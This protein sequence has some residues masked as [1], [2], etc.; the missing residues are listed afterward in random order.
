[1]STVAVK[2]K[3]TQN[4]SIHLLSL[5]K[6]CRFFTVEEAKAELKDLICKV[7]DLYNRTLLVKDKE[8]YEEIADI[9]QPKWKV[10]TFEPFKISIYALV[11]RD[12]SRLSSWIE[13]L[14]TEKD[15]TTQ[16]IHYLFFLFREREI[17]K[18]IMKEIFAL[19]TGN[20]Y[21][22]VQKFSDYDFPLKIAKRL[23]EPKIHRATKRPVVGPVLQLSE[24]LKQNAEVLES[25]SLDKFFERT[26]LPFRKDSSIFNLQFFQNKK[27][28]P[29]VKGM[30]ADITL[31]LVRLSKEIAPEN[32]PD[33]LHHFSRIAN[34]EKTICFGKKEKEEK[35]SEEFGF[36]EHFKPVDFTLTPQLNKALIQKIF[37]FIYHDVEFPPLDFCHKHRND[38]FQSPEFTLLHAGASIGTPWG[39]A[40]SAVDVMERLKAYFQKKKFKE[41]EF[42]KTL[43]ECSFS[44]Q[45]E[46][47]IKSAPLVDYLEGELRVKHGEVYWR[48]HTMWYEIHADYLGLI[49]EEFRRMLGQC[50]LDVSKL[51]H[52][53]PSPESKKE[54][55]QALKDEGKKKYYI[56]E[57][58]N[59][60][61]LG[62]KDYFL[63]D[64]ICPQG[65][66]LG[67]VFHVDKEKLYLFHV[68]EGFKQSTRDACSQILNAAK[69][70]HHHG[71]KKKTPIEVIEEFYE[72][73]C[74]GGDSS[75]RKKVKEEISKV[76][77]RDFVKL[78]SKKFVF[79]YAFADDAKGQRLLATEKDVSLSVTP[80]EIEKAHNKFKGQGKKL[81][82]ALQEEGYLTKKGVIKSRTQLSNIL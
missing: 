13:K 8:I 38:Y 7:V 66:E 46:G 48:L 50:L 17:G 39:T 53:W 23:M 61:Y 19:T 24:I 73:A 34:Q 56:E 51:P 12:K 65:I 79:V 67:D 70:L 26:N 58:Y 68:K 63:G 72:M 74:Q 27:G 10:Q 64:K 55:K 6:I 3:A 54:R 71:G 16:K 11:V 9:K 43:K 81:Y 36:L 5:R 1:M 35:D 22:V 14:G 59:Q 15:L 28:Q 20:G 75:Y 52:L 69:L 33:I 25:D 30:N 62:E 29:L 32:Y 82:Q 2:E 41:K 49:H 42:E 44:F 77:K 21:R 37:D 80:A 45:Q 60:T 76:K 40:P 31:S 4:L 57:E 78:F 47:K 18:R